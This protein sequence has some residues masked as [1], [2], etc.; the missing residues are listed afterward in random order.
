MN[1]GLIEFQ[2]KKTRELLSYARI[3]LG[4]RVRNQPLPS[5]TF[6]DGVDKL[7]KSLNAIKYVYTTSSCGGHLK[8][9]YHLEGNAPHVYGAVWLEYATDFI[10]S[11]TRILRTKQLSTIDL[12]ISTPARK[13]DHFWFCIKSRSEP[14]TEESLKKRRK[15]FEGLAKAVLRLAHEHPDPLWFA[16]LLGSKQ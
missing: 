15:D 1:T 7:A 10:E 16:L 11:I 13:T 6:E 2:K 12:I 5:L 3:Y 4:F 14:E 8:D 9:N